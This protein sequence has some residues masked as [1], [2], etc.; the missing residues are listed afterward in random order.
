MTP[1]AQ[2]LDDLEHKLAV[3]AAIAASRADALVRCDRRCSEL[4]SAN[5]D[6]IE[7]VRLAEERTAKAEES[8]E[9]EAAR[10]HRLREHAG[11]YRAW[12]GDARRDVDDGIGMADGTR[13]ATE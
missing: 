9:V 4:Q 3:E 12:R 8:L 6:L 11:A 2:R 7:A 1:E 13:G 5:R 10:V